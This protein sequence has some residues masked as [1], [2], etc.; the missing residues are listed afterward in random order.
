MNCR[1]LD[2]KQLNIEIMRT[3]ENYSAQQATTLSKGAIWNTKRR[4]TFMNR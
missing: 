3:S 2:I 4:Y 1:L